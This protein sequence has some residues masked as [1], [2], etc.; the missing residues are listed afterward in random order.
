MSG[1]TLS[2]ILLGLILAVLGAG[3]GVLM[4]FSTRIVRVEIGT[5]AWQLAHDKQDDTR[6]REN[7]ERFRVLNENT[8]LVRGGLHDIQGALTNLGLKEWLD[9]RAQQRERDRVKKKIEDPEVG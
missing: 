7:V 8:D 3:V 6:H 1:E 9:A 2:N 5:V 4:R